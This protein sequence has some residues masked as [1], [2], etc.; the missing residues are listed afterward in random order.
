LCGREGLVRGDGDLCDYRNGL[1]LHAVPEE[2]GGVTLI[3]ARAPA[4]WANPGGMTLIGEEE[5]A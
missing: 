3:G 5:R 4:A 2:V 1:V